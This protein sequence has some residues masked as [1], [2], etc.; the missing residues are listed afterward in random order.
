MPPRNLVQGLRRGRALDRVVSED[1]W[2]SRIQL[3]S[4]RWSREV[5]EISAAIPESP[6]KPG[7]GFSFTKQFLH[8]HPNTASEAGPVR[9]ASLRWASVQKRGLFS[10]GPGTG[11]LYWGPHCQPSHASSVSLCAPYTPARAPSPRTQKSPGF[12]SVES[13]C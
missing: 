10:L 11:I 6:A 2:L 9:W 1:H 8:P 3:R 5:Q 12:A 7:P 13:N 4:R